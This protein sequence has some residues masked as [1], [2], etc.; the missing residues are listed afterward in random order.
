MKHVLWRQRYEM[1]S[2]VYFYRTFDFVDFLNIY[3]RYQRAQM[4]LG[5][6]SVHVHIHLWKRD[7]DVGLIEC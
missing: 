5:Q 2:P 3:L 6:G 7:G 4:A 1:C